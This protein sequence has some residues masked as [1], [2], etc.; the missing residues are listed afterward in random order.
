MSRYI[1]LINKASS[2]AIFT[3]IN[4]DGDAI[5]SSLTLR[6]MLINMGKK[7]DI[8]VDST[9]PYHIQFLPGIECIN[10]K[11]CEKYDLH[12]ALDSASLDRLGRKKFKFGKKTPSIQIDHH[13][14][15]PNFAES[16]IVD[17]KASSTCE[18]LY[19]VILSLNQKIDKDMAMCLIVGIFTDTGNL[20]FSNAKESTFAI[21][22]KLLQ[23][24]GDSIDTIT[25]PLNNSISMDVFN[26]KK[27]V[28]QT[29]D[30]RLD[31]KLAICYLDDK[32][33]KKTNTSIDDTKGLVYVPFELKSVKM[34][35]ILSKDSEGAIYGSIRTKG[36]F[37]AADVAESFGGGGHINAAG[38]KSYQSYE[39]IKEQI[40]KEAKKVLL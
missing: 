19:N 14:G 13:R 28:Y 15:N 3:H 35:A 24:Y 10:E 39:E 22:S 18:L 17:E 37:S 23:I 34:A 30:F 36:K 8:I 16:N 27:Y 32:I 40:I 31:N 1:E 12:I 11:T 7:A 2:V 9:I 33:F 26:L 6:K 25:E 5:G 21:V 38:F 29:I 20:T 4:T